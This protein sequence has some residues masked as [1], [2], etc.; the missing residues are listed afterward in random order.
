VDDEL[1][2]VEQAMA[3]HQVR[4]V[5]IVDAAGCCVGIIAQ[6][7]LALAAEHARLSEHEVAVVVEKISEPSRPLAAA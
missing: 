6:A 2:A 4:R 1:D 5:P 3:D 7:D